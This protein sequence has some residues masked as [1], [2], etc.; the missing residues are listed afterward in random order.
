MNRIILNI[1]GLLLL[2]T[3]CDKEDIQRYDRGRAAIEFDGSS[4][5]YSF[6]KTS[7]SV[8]TVS[9]PFSITGYPE[10]RI[11]HAE[12]VV[13]A[14]STTATENEYKVIDA[15]VASGA[16]NGQLRV[17][18]ENHS[19]DDFEEVRVYFQIASNE[20]FIPGVSERN[21]YVL[22]LT[23]ELVRPDSWDAWTER[24]SLGTYSTAYY[25]FIIEASG[26]TEFPIHIPVPGINDGQTWDTGQKTA[27]LDKLK[28]ELKA[29][30]KHE[31]KPLLHDDGTAKGQEVVV[32]KYYNN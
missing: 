14:D 27:F 10:E 30:N 11:R 7:R 28:E 3:S 24:Y 31:G 8:D 5:A 20:D 29:R 2:F 15:V 6:K 25:Q 12:F 1:I 4:S 13:V 26:M 16:Y 18:V 19:G 23:N 9:I 22:T 21:H 17:R 32:G